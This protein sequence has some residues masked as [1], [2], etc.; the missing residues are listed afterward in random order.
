[1]ASHYE[2][3]RNAAFDREVKKK[4]ARIN[5][6][7]GIGRYR[8]RNDM[9]KDLGLPK[10]CEDG[11]S[12]IAPG[13]SFVGDSYF[14][15]IP[16]LVIL[17]VIDDGKPKEVKP[18]SPPEP[19]PAAMTQAAT[20]A[21]AEVKITVKDPQPKEAEPSVKE[22]EVEQLTKK[23]EERGPRRPKPQLRITRSSDDK[24][25]GDEKEQ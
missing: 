3:A 18:V 24:P 22:E 12:W 9:R 10:P 7:S 21:Q 17:E 6:M 25:D 8:Y 16:G 4:Q 20:Q 23:N 1:M 5:S 19:K 14:Q 13:A 2:N 15:A 11:R